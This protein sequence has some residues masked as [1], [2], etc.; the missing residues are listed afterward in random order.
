MLKSAFLAGAVLSLQA[1]V[2]DSVGQLSPEA[3]SVTV[4][5]ETSRP[6]DCK[7]LGKINGSS[8]ASKEKQARE[9]AEND[10]RNQAA[11]MKANYALIEQ[12]RSGPLG[13]TDQIDV[14]IGGKALFCR[15]PEMEAEEEKKHEQ[16]LKDKEER[17][18]KE[19]EEKERKAQEEKEKSEAEKE[20]SKK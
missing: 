8:H 2:F 17:E 3:K 14:F 12:E 19:A 15:T 11:K 9:G 20:K 7:V 18:Q 13:T 1:C 4:V 16:A 6:I 10:F 5:H